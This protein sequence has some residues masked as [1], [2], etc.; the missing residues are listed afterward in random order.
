MKHITKP[1]ITKNLFIA[2]VLSAVFAVLLALSIVITVISSSLDD[3]DP[4]TVTEVPSVIDGEAR[5]N[6][7]ALAYPSI[8]RK[9]QIF[10]LIKS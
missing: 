7:L 3:S 1:K 5:Q 2:I 4:Q 6:G 8:N 10:S 9:N